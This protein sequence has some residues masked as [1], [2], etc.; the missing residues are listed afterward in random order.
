M[1]AALLAAAL[2][3][4][5]A[6]AA[7]ILLGGMEPLPLAALLYL[8]GGLGALG[9]GILIRL[10]DGGAGHEAAIGRGDLPWLAG[11]I[12]FGG[13]VAPVLLFTGLR[14]TSAPVAS[15]LLN[16]EAAATTLI[17]VFVF[18]EWV[19]RRVWIAIGCI[20]FGSVLL[21]RDA[22]AAIGLSVGATGIIGACISWGL[23]N[24]ITRA[25]SGKNPLAIAMSKGL[26]A[27]SVSLC[28]AILVRS[29]VPS[30]QMTAAALLLGVLCY[31]TSTVLFILSLR[32]LGAARTSALFATAPFVGTV[33][34][35][36]IF[37]GP[38][39]LFFIVA[40]IVMAAGALLLYLEEHS[41]LHRHERLEHEHRHRH[42]D[43]HHD[44]LHREKMPAEHSHVHVHE[45]VEH[46]HSH[47]PDLHHRH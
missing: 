32:D 44:H 22:G 40:F 28:L 35:F 29:A 21:I 15:L 41:H 43:G 3:G 14:T 25:I 8:G 27:G 39:D 36:L 18:R 45:P 17:A 42:D 16:F 19:G 20:T 4:A 33:L 1:A 7:K 46:S 12:L 24:N 47:A 2:F 26:I 31:G 37:R 11:T 38:P 34:S 9:P 13:I 30:I 6:P 23:D 10:R 5:S